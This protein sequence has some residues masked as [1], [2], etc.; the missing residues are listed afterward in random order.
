MLRK[1]VAA[2]IFSASFAHAT[3]VET[4]V[5]P[6]DVAPNPAKIAV[7]DV[8][9]VDTLSALGVSLS[10]VVEN[11]YVDYLDEAVKGVAPVGNIFE[12]DFE[13]V[14]ALQPD[15]IIVG[16]RSSTQA[17]AL[18]NLAPTIDMTIWED[19]VGQGLSRLDA[20][21]KIFN[22]EAEA[23]ALRA[24]FEEKLAL[25]KTTLEN[26]GSGLIVLTNGPK[27]SAYGAG[28]RFGWIH[29]DLALPEAVKEVEQATHGEAISFEFIKDANPD[30]LIVIDR[31]A[32]IGQPGQGAAETLDNALVK[33]TKA[34]TQGN[35]VYLNAKDIYISGGGIQSMSRTLDLFLDVLAS[36]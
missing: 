25:V 2:L 14:N 7:F 27:I 35:V 33:E 9:A 19:T 6:V 30:I 3:E 29:K 31:L 17:Q 36:K 21:G 15:L 12:P 5:G 22:K 16:G 34:W 26:K 10:G 18:V 24:A 32:A 23:D 4:Y 8:S 11:V 28:G 1:L 13:A 20:Y